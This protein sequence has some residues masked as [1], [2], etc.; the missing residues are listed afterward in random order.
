MIFRFK[1]RDMNDN[2]TNP[3]NYDYEKYEN[4]KV[5]PILSIAQ[6]RFNG[7]VIHCVGKDCMWYADCMRKELRELRGT[8]LRQ[9]R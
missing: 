5:C 1:E 8:P 4:S 2:E 7:C 3:Y 9:L 6:I